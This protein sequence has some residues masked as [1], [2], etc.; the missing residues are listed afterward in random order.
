[1]N[2]YSCN[3]IWQ[4]IYL[5]FEITVEFVEPQITSTSSTTTEY[6]VIDDTNPWKKRLPVYNDRYSPTQGLENHNY[7]GKNIKHWYD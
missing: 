7:R 6:L 3:K 1:M 2:K 4:I 5:I